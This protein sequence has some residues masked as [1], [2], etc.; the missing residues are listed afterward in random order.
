MINIVKGSPKY[1]FHYDA[2]KVFCS[3]YLCKKDAN[4]QFSPRRWAQ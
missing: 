3:N 4:H 2:G 1:F